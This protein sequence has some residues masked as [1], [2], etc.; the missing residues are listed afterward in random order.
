LDEALGAAGLLSKPGGESSISGAIAICPDGQRQLDLR[1]VEINSTAHGLLIAPVS[2]GWQATLV[3]RTH[4][5]TSVAST[6]AGLRG[7]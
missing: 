1:R 7:F 5:I 2:H 3:A 4:I 6:D